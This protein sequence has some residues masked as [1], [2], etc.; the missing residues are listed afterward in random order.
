LL[1]TVPA[2]AALAG[3]GLDSLP[4]MRRRDG[5][6]AQ[7]Y[8]RVWCV[9]WVFDRRYPADLPSP[10]VETVREVAAG[11]GVALT[12]AHEDNHDDAGGGD[13]GLQVWRFY[14]RVPD[15]GQPAGPARD[16][17]A[18]TDHWV[19]PTSA[20][21]VAVLTLAGLI[22]GLAC[23]SG[24]T[25][26]VQVDFSPTLTTLEHLSDLV[27]GT[28]ATQLA[29]LESAFTRFRD[30][31]ADTTGRP[32]PDTLVSARWDHDQGAVVGSAAFYVGQDAP[33][34]RVVQAG[35]APQDGTESG[36][37]HPVLPTPTPLIGPDTPWELAL[38]DGFRVTAPLAQAI[39]QM[40]AHLDT[41]PI[42]HN[43]SDR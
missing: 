12:D 5:S 27:R 9:Q 1:I 25:G 4:G 10:V 19:M 14:L 23:E 16:R 2:A 31:Y 13:P 21:P 38:S 36:Q 42:T 8:D 26:R 24:L 29:A 35:L 18:L 7:R 33:R 6:G 30:T 28:Y 15:V 22:A 39:R 3:D 41:L 43:P 17:D 34:W 32:L 20:W 37:D 40:L 11:L